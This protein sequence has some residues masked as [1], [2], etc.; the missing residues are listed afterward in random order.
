MATWRFI[1]SPEDG[2]IISQVL[3][4]DDCTWVTDEYFETPSEIARISRE[5]EQGISLGDRGWVVAAK[6]FLMG[7][8]L[9]RKIYKVRSP[10][11]KWAVPVDNMLYC[12]NSMETLK[13]EMPTAVMTDEP[14]PKECL[15][16]SLWIEP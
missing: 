9:G 4:N 10:Y 13:K 12:Y 2:V 16:L 8:N 1:E 5:I 7:Q 15:S 3:A 11:F 14:L 6:A